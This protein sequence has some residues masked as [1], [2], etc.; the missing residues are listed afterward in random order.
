M[1]DDDLDLS[2]DFICLCCGGRNGEDDPACT[3]RNYP[4][5]DATRPELPEWYS[6]Q[7]YDSRAWFRSAEYLGSVVVPANYVVSPTTENYFKDS[8][9]P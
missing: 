9:T 2:Y 8:P 6:E 1:E 3:V 4:L 7:E 5:A